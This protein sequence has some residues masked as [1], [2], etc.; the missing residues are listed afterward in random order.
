TTLFRSPQ[1]LASSAES[2]YK[3]FMATPV[4]FMHLHLENWRNFA[5][6]DVELQRRVFVVGP[7]ASGK[8][9]LLDVFRFLHD[10]VA[11]G[12]GL[13]EAVRKRQGVSKL[14]AL[15]ARKVPDIVIDVELGGV[16]GTTWRY[17]L[18]LA[19]D[20]QHRPQ[21]KRES[22]WHNSRSLFSRPDQSDTSDPERLT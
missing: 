12:G 7:N 21:I 15:A 19:H 9:N 8:S 20:K 2:R 18:A 11:V 22:V 16:N 17:E 6:A 4:S 1:P 13:E 10:I 5:N 14:R 3:I